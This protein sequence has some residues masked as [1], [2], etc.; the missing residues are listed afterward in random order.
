MFLPSAV[1][2]FLKLNPLD[3]NPSNKLGHIFKK[4]I[5]QRR[6]TGVRYGDLSELLDDAI[7]KGLP[8]TEGEKIGNTLIAFG[9]GVETVSNALCRIFQYLVENPEVKD[10]LYAEVKKEFSNGIEYDQL[11]QHQ[12]L[13]A[14]INEC[15]RLGTAVFVQERR[16]MQ[17]TKIGEFEIAKGTE[18]YVI[19]YITHHSA[20]Y[21]PSKFPLLF[22]TDIH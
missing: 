16:A 2:R 10:R 8:M 19:P 20:E 1:S 17:D 9:A 7:D 4:M 3:V 6:A 21:W 22:A 12:Y 5:K 15:L 18:I 11:T 13:D 14:F